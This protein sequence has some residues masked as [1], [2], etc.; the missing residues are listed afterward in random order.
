MKTC[1]RC[2][3]PKAPSE[4]AS[5]QKYCRPCQRDYR[6]EH[7]KT[8]EY[9]RRYYARH[10]EKKLTDQIERKRNRIR[11]LKRERGGACERCGYDRYLGSLA[12][13]HRDPTTKEF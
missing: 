9:C 8:S 4:F 5:N 2:R 11:T 1:S 6:R 12:F 7:N 3:Q 13:H 10:R